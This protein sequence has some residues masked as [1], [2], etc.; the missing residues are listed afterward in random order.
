MTKFLGLIYPQIPWRAIPQLLL[1]GVLGTVIAGIYGFL[2]DQVTY[3]ISHEYFTLFKFDQFAHADFG[4]GNRMFAGTIGFLATFWIGAIAGWVFGRLSLS[5]GSPQPDFPKTLQAIA[6]TFG[7]CVI[8]GCIGYCWGIIM[9]PYI[10]S[11]WSDWR[12][13]FPITD[14][15]AFA[16]VGYIH[17][18]GYIGGVVGS[19][20]AGIRLRRQIRR[21]SDQKNVAS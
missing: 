5:P 4:W 8:F 13:L 6:I 18:M 19:I 21:K 16:T 3:S 10:E 9:T 11:R 7:I 12:D 14:L 17:N 2:H 1:L 20:I 15:N